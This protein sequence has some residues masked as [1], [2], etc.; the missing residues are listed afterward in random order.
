VLQVKKLLYAWA[1]TGVIVLAGGMTGCTVGPDFRTPAA[2][3][4]KAYTETPLVAETAAT[5]GGA[6]SAQKFVSGRDIPGQWWTMYRSEALDRLIRQALSDSP[7]LAA[8]QATLSE[9]QENLHARTGTEYFPGVDGK[10]SLSRQK[11]S[12]A[13][14]GQPG[15]GST[16]FNLINAS[17]NVSY[18]LD[19]FGGGRRELEGLRAQVDYQRFQLEGAYLALTSNI[20]TTAVQEASLREQLRATREILSFQQEQLDLIERRF[21]LGGAARSDVLAQK[22]QLA[23]TR[24]GVP[25]LEKQLARSRHLLAVLAGRFPGASGLPEFEIRG[26]Q[27]PVELPVSLPSSLVRQRPDI[28]ASEELLHAASAQLGVVTANMYPNITLSGSLGSSATKISDL[29]SPGSSVW[30]LGAGVLQPIFHAG[31]LNARRRAAAAA[32]DQAA[33][34]YRET[35]LQAFRNVA[36]V[37][38]ALEQDA[39]ALKA[40]AEAEAAA[41]ESLELARKQYRFGA[42]SYLLLLDAERQ[43]QQAVIGL[44]QAQSARF[45][46][47]AALF[48]A[49]GG[50]WWNREPGDRVATTARGKAD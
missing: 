45:A 36:D 3:V 34:L 38:R 32:Y 22:A 27:L 24:A 19:I 8:A 21:Q 31:E 7:T 12:G 42:A 33:A 11:S 30:S 9:A 17:V 35:V 13:S 6:G 20:V 37:L 16:I 18:T 50:G 14:F 26:L 29:F 46:D 25:P 40:Q 43:H 15:V 44:V 28:R 2:P 39:E 41:R 1:A 49:L 48:Q 23:Q 4:A 47:T 10:L 5:A